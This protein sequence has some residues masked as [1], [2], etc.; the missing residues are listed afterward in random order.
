MYS[1]WQ[2]NAFIGGLSSQA[3]IRVTFE[4]TPL[5]N[6]GSGGTSSTMET[7]ANEA[8]RFEWGKRI[9]EVEQGPEGAIYALEDGEGGRLIRLTPGD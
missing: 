9:R 6:Q 5:D 3:L 2:G 4:K 1:D 8:E 7:T